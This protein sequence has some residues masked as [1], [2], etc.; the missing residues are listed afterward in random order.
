MKKSPMAITAV[1]LLAGSPALAADMALKAPPLAVPSWNWSGFYG[2]V[3]AG[4]GWNQTGGIFSCSAPGGGNVG[5]PLWSTVMWPQGG[6]AGG[7]VGYNWQSGMLVYGVETDLQWSGIHSSPTLV[8]PAGIT[9]IAGGGV[10]GVP[11]TFNVTDN[12]TWFGTARLRFGVTP[13]PR[14]LVYVT[15]GL[16]YGQENVSFN[17]TFPTTGITYLANSSSTRVGGT[18]GLGIEYAFT[19]NFSGKIEGLY[20]DM[21]SQTIAFTN[22]ITGF[23]ASESFAYEGFIVRGGLN[24]RLSS[25]A[26]SAT[27]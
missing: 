13:T 15:G 26:P 27:R 6:L 3:D 18:F 17:N 8:F 5:C 9:P 22:P 7:Q 23:T 21:G 12:L 11:S 19:P 25:I 16:F 20:Y 2:G 4:F 1:A 10:V 14:A 24:V